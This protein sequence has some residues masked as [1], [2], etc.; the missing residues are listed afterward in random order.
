M[1]NILFI[2][3]L[4]AVLLSSQLGFCALI[5]LETPAAP[6]SAGGK[7]KVE[8]AVIEEGKKLWKV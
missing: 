1:K 7:A 5:N 3:A 6:D 2:V 4:V 8:G